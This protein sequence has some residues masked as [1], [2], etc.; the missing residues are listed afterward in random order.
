[1]VLHKEG[2]MLY[3]GVNKLVAENLDTLAED[4]II[5]TFPTGGS[6]D[7]GHQS[8]EGD[9]LLKA[10]RSTWEDHIGNMT[11]LGQLL[12]YM[13]TFCPILWNPTNSL[14]IK[15]RVHTKTAN[16]P[17]ISQAGL[18]LFLKHIIR[19]PI[20]DHV[21]AAIL[22]QIQ[23]E[24]DGYSIN[25]SSVKGCV[26]VLRSLWVDEASNITVYQ[27]YLEPAFLRE[28]EAFYKAEGQKLLESCDAPE[29]LARVNP[30]SA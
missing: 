15:D 25:Q 22:N 24:R 29:F 7:P 4:R 16:V 6:S 23:F 12:K 10:L 1:M 20:R 27:H 19:P 8:Q 9:V 18:T 13:V 26:D 17:E 21:I 5:P 3:D 14:D 28:S 11:K 30:S 2:K